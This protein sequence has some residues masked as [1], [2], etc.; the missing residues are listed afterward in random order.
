MLH[1]RQEESMDRR[2]AKGA[3][4]GGAWLAH[5]TE[6]AT[7]DLGVVNSSPVLGVQIT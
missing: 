4:E 7:P 1:V 5:S 6:H 2:K 3:G